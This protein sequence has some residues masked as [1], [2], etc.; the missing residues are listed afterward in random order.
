MPLGDQLENQNPT[1]YSKSADRLVTQEEYDDTI[2]DEF[3][4]REI[5]G[6]Y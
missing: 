3:D 6:D 1:L 2:V 4:Q 5:F